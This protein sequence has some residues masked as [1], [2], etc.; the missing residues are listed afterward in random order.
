MKIGANIGEYMNKP[1]SSLS[2]IIATAQNEINSSNN[3]VISA[4]K[5]LR[6]DLQSYYSQ[7]DS[8]IALYVDSK[9][10]ATSLA[11]PMNRQL[12]ILSQRGAQ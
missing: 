6:A 11:R 3:E 12:N 7:D 1:I 9:K 2:N 8:E 5:G 4:I 10:L